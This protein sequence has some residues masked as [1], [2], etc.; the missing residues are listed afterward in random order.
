MHALVCYW[1]HRILWYFTPT[2][3]E[4]FPCEFHFRSQTGRWFK[5]K[6]IFNLAGK[7][8][9]GISFPECFRLSAKHPIRE[10]NLQELRSCS[11]S[12]NNNNNNIEIVVTP[13]SSMAN[14]KNKILFWQKWVANQLTFSP[15]LL[16]V[17]LLLSYKR[18]YFSADVQPNF[19]R[20]KSRF[21]LLPNYF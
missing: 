15:F 11:L 14:E 20:I 8:S 9:S 1:K 10:C 4:P 2:D 21:C 6:N 17:Y 5:K 19:A 12:N 18:V 3:W 16:N 7:I 13:R